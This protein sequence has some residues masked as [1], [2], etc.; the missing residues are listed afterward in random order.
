[1]NPTQNRFMGMGLWPVAL[2][3]LATAICLVV[4]FASILAPHAIDHYKGLVALGIGWLFWSFTVTWTTSRERFDVQVFLL[5]V[6]FFPV[7]YPACVLFLLLVVAM[8]DKFKAAEHV[9]S[10]G[11][12]GNDVGG[13][14]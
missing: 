6:L 1:M 11:P 8:R 9:A 12:E 10:P 3:C 5:V 2:I 13:L 14:G 4:F 7:M